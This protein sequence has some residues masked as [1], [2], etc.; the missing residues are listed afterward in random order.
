MDCYP[1]FAK[2][3]GDC[4]CLQHADGRVT[5][6]APAINRPG[7][8][9]D[10]LAGSAGWGD[11]SILVPWAMY[12]QTGDK[13]IL[14]ENYPMMQRWYSYLESRARAGKLKKLLKQK[15][16]T[17]QVSYTASARM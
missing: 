7:F 15:R 11:A 14:E 9:T 10:M 12:Q 3:L 4:R 5:M 8:M 16:T 6:I 13:S 2:W 17:G 1:V